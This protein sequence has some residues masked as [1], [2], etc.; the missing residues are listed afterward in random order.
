MRLFAGV[1][2]ASL[3]I[4]CVPPTAS[5]PPVPTSDFLLGGI[6]VN[7]ADH[8]VW[9]QKLRERGFD[10]VSI[11]S[12]AKQ[13]DWDSSNLWWEDE[14]PWVVEEIRGAKAAGLRVAL[15]PRVALDH[16]FPRNRFLWHG[17]IYPGSDADVEEWFRRYRQ[18]VLRW[19]KVAAE[20]QV[21]VFGI[22]SEMRA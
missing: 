17:M 9:F 13:G 5:A 15:I 10:T 20:H 16:A 8:S 7:E 22:G 11:T 19:A 6:Q 21:D 4:G 18:F 3:A 2:A 1:L 12:Y 14:E